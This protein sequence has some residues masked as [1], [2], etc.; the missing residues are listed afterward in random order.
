MSS[1][2]LANLNAQGKLA[3]GALDYLKKNN[4][5]KFSEVEFITEQKIAVDN[6]NKSSKRLYDK[7]IGKVVE[8]PLSALEQMDADLNKIIMSDPPSIRD[9]R[10]KYYDDNKEI[11][12]IAKSIANKE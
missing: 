1:G 8:K 4:P 11:K 12:N 10:K 7:S 3:S 2:Q 6:I 9:L 5:T